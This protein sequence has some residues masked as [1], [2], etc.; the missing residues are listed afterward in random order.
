MSNFLG[1]WI[2]KKNVKYEA[3]FLARSEKKRYDITGMKKA[4]IFFL[5]FC[6]MICGVVHTQ[7]EGVETGEEKEKKVDKSVSLVLF[8]PGLFQFR[9]RQYIKGIMFLGAFSGCVAGAIASNNNGNHWYER[10][11]RSLNVDDIVRY[12]EI[13]EQRFKTRNF[14]I[15]GIF[16][17]WLVHLLDV[18]LFKSPKT[19]VKSDVG[20]NYIS[21]GFYHFF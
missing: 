10:Y 14:F 5:C 6:V 21:I 3:G 16:T 8:I 1:G 15:A 2:W 9:H 7:T 17:V 13:T 12:R 4:M 19:G 20:Q 18:K 11:K